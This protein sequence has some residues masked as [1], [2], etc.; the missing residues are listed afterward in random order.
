[1]SY[2]N[3]TTEQ[4]T[5]RDFA[6]ALQKARVKQQKKQQQNTQYIK[7]IAKTTRPQRVFT[8]SAKTD[9][10]IKQMIQQEQRYYQSIVHLQQQKKK[11]ARLYKKYTKIIDGYHRK[12]WTLLYA[13]A[14]LDAFID[15]INIPVVSTIIS[16]GTSFYLNTAL[17]RVGS[18]EKRRERRLKR[19][20]ISFIDLIPIINMF[21]S[22]IF[23]VY[24]AH[25]EEKKRVEDAKRKIK[26]LNRQ[27]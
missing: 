3:V 6:R 24:F 26:Q 22:S 19:F 7:K 10:Q 27:H 8:K 20:I 18:P 17:W 16:S 25:K 4:A 14:A 11:K 15:A 9:A 2:N 1:M 12:P 23:I 13:V 5:Q 21:P